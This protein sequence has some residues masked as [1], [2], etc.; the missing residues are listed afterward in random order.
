MTEDTYTLTEAEW[1]DALKVGMDA[2]FEARFVD[3]NIAGAA[4]I[5]I[6]AGRQ[7]AIQIAQQR[8]NGGR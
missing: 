3:N 2:A 6:E 4:D 8:I 5:G 7:R 1:A